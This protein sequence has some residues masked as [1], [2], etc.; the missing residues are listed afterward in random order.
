MQKK[1]SRIWAADQVILVALPEPIGRVSAAFSTM[2]M[3]SARRAPASG[4]RG[5]RTRSTATHDHLGQFDRLDQIR[6]RIQV[7]QRHEPAIDLKG[8]GDVADLNR[9]D[10]GH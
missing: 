2:A 8:A 1:T 6:N 4:M 3:T 10:P 7:K 5:M 9:L